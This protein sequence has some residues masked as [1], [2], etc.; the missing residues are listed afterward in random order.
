MAGNNVDLEA[1]NDRRL[2]S[3]GCMT[4]KIREEARMGLED[5]WSTGI[6]VSRTLI[7]FVLT[8]NDRIEQST[9]RRDAVQELLENLRLRKIRQFGGRLGGTLAKLGC[10]TGARLNVCKSGS[11]IASFVTR[12]T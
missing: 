2:V 11:F 4:R 7:N 9:V 6:S 1:G 3:V 8:A 12:K 5:S 10:R